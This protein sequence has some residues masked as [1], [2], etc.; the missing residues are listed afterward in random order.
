MALTAAAASGGDA[1]DDEYAKLVRGMNPPRVVVDNEACDEATV[2]RVDSVSSHGTLLAVVQV[3]A[4]LGL[5]IRKAYFS[6]DG[7]WFMDVFNVT[8]RDGNKV[9]D[10]QTISY[11]QTTLEADD[12]YYPEVRNTVGIVPAEEYTVIELTG[13]DRPGLLSEVCAVLAGM[14]CAVRSAELWTHNTRVAAVVHVTDDGGSGGAIED[15]ARIAD[16]STRLGNLLRGQSGVRAAAAAAPGGLTHKERRLHQMMFDDRDYDGGGG[17]A[18]SSPRGR[19]PT[20]ATEVSVTPCAER[21]YTAVVVRCRD[22]PKLLFDTV[23]TITDMGYVIHHGAVSSEPRGGAYQEYYIRHVDGDPVRSEAERQ[24]VVQC[25]EA[26]IERRTADGLALEVRTGDR[27]GLLSDVT[28]IFRENGLTIRRAE[29]SSERGEAV[30]T[31]YLSDPQGHPVE[32]KTIDAIRAQIGEATLRVK[33]NPFA[34]GDGAGGGGGGATDDVAGSTAFLFGNLFKFYRPF[35]NFS[36][37]KLY[38]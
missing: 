17:A 15:E 21:G 9:L 34:D 30:D 38:S 35:Q 20:P 18:S 7:S 3:I 6:S 28:R 25:L 13:T 16:I 12:W 8:D 31:F 4:D 27:A 36:L 23:C 24:R 2:I 26:A 5:V 32:A 10:D 1:H 37:I 29:I 22:R 14:R 19:S 11:I 33:H